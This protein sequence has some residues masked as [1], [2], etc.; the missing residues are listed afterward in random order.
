[1]TASMSVSGSGATAHEHAG[2][3][4]SVNAMYFVTAD[5]DPGVAL[6]L[7]EPFSKL[8][9]VPG[10]VHISSEDGN[11]EDM[12]ADL[13]IQDVTPKTAHVIDKALRSI[14]GVR[15]VIALVE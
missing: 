1:M 14:I 8:G 9:L 12:S 11:G 5:A 13:R 4:E 6:R 2:E 15:Q 10:R 7:I 3:S